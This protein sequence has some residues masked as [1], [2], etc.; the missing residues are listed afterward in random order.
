MD[1]SAHSAMPR[2]PK[3]LIA[4]STAGCNL[5]YAI[6]CTLPSRFRHALLKFLLRG[7][8][9]CCS[10][11]FR[12]CRSLTRESLLFLHENTQANSGILIVALLSRDGSVNFIL[13]MLRKMSSRTFISNRI[14]KLQ[15]FK[16][17]HL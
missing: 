17:V 4:D 14:E 5:R 16:R 11:Y 12:H 10:S 9:L 13:C 15:T 7:Q 8:I 1:I 2:Y 6:G 3:L